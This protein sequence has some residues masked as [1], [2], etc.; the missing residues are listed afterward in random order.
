MRF[1]MTLGKRIASGI[2]LMLVL[3]VAVGIAGYVGLS[4]VLGVTG[5]YQEMNELQGLIASVKG[6]T[7]QYLLAC[8]MGDSKA[9]GDSIKA[10]YARLD[11]ALAAIDQVV[12]VEN[13]D[14]ESKQKLAVAKGEVNQY[15]KAL[16]G[17]RASEEAKGTIEKAL[18]GAYDPLL[19]MIKSGEIWFEEMIFS[20]KVLQAVATG[21]LMRPSPLNWKGVQDQAGKAKEDINVWQKK[22]EGSEKLSEVAKTIQTQFDEISAK[23]EEHQGQVLSQTAFRA[24]MESHKGKL[25]EICAYMG[26]TSMERLHGQTRSSVMLI[27]GFILA[28]LV[29][30]IGY[31]A[32]SIR[33]IVSRLK[34]VIQGI[35]EGAGQVT[36][37]AGQVSAA[38]QVLAEGASEQAASIEESSS[39]LEE[40]SS[41]TARNA[42]HAGEANALMQETR[43]VVGSANETISELTTSMEGISNASDETS[44]IIKAID[45]IAFQTNL[46]A[47]NAA[48]EA[49]RAGQAGAGFAVVA[50]EVRNLAMRAAEAARN[51]AGLIEE[52]I[53]RVK[54]G[55]G[56]VTRTN[57]A[58]L[59]VSESAGKVA[60]LVGEIAAASRE[61]A[62]GI[63][64]VNKAVSEMDRVVQQAA[65]SA[66][67]SASSAE[68]MNAQAT[69]MKEFVQDLVVLVVGSHSR[70]EDGGRKEI[71]GA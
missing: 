17:F 39:S 55:R 63:E 51:T 58:F 47:L 7:D 69:Q 22:V 65:A 48:V 68:E 4:R 26:K 36:N 40:M 33:G 10:T 2:A 44:K 31:A 46:L 70:A 66:E 30:G 11:S 32:F 37:G 21:Y 62:Q 60:E 19:E 5:F 57:E 14:Q 43:Q 28:A 64:Q 1:E 8:S 61:Q 54:D 24:R 23:L 18:A 12:G 45:E 25:D 42:D 56:L 50:D 34:A 15:R 3:M 59:K 29:V 38:S 71:S 35:S 52:T 20:A 27:F 41:M 67:E 13:V 49:A 53:K 9:A 6:H 16:D